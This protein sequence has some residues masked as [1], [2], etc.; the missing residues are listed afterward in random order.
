MKNTMFAE[1]TKEKFEAINSL[2][3]ELIECVAPDIEKTEKA[4]PLEK[5]H[6]LHF[7]RAM[8]ELR[9]ALGFIHA[10][11][12]MPEEEFEKLVTDDGKNSLEEVEMK[13]MFSM[14]MKMAEAQMNRD[15]EED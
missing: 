9:E 1:N 3:K 14:M 11:L 5:V 8:D 7:L 12:E 4:S 15:K 6:T 2:S 13:L 10:L